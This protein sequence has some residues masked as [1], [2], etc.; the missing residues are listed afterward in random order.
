MLPVG[1]YV[2]KTSRA[3]APAGWGGA[4]R[5]SIQSNGGGG[6][7]GFVWLGGAVVYSHTPRGRGAVLRGGPPPPETDDYFS[8]TV[9]SPF[10]QVMVPPVNSLLRLPSGRVSSSVTG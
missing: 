8:V 5:G 6:W 2:G 7:G 1:A 3:G 10:I 9:V 4:R